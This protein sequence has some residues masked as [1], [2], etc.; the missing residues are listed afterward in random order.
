MPCSACAKARARRA[1]RMKLREAR[2]AEKAAR[3]DNQEVKIIIPKAYQQAAA[4]LDDSNTAV[5]GSVN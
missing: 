5:D 3:G 4:K 2:L 1:E